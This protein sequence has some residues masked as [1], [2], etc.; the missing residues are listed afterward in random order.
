MT[1][2][3]YGISQCGSCKKA[4]QWL[5]ENEVDYQFINIKEN[6]PDEKTITEGAVKYLC[7]INCIF[8]ICFLNA[9]SLTIS[10]LPI[11]YINLKM[12]I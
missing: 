6:P 5:S 2:L 11:F 9:K 4:R 7:K 12:H 1:L 10:K 8:S 3:V